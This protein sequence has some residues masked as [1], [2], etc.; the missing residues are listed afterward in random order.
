MT[1]TASTIVAAAT[2]AAAAAAPTTTTATTKQLYMNYIIG[3]CQCFGETYSLHHQ[4]K[5]K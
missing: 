4:G 5:I 2:A 3:I 1:I